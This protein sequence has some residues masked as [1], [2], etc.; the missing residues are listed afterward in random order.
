LIVLLDRV[1]SY[2]HILR[3]YLRENQEIRCDTCGTS[4]EVEKLDSL[5]LFGM[6][7]PSCFGGT[8]RITNLSRKY[9]GLLRDFNQDLLLPQTELGIVQTLHS[10]GRALFA[11]EIAGELDCSYQLVGK[12]GKSLEYR[13]LVA[14]YKKNRRKFELT[15]SAVD[16][17]FDDEEVGDLQGD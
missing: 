7:C 2:S 16:A 13:G 5:K 10:Q 1:F 12:R 3:A 8:V 14:R 9:E 15:K 11:A 4:F 17:Y 6:R